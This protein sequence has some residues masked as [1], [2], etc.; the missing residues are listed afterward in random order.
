MVLPDGRPLTVANG[1]LP[2]P[3][4]EGHVILWLPGES[5]G[6][7]QDWERVATVARA[8]VTTAQGVC[9]IAAA[10]VPIRRRLRGSLG[11]LLRAL[12]RPRADRT[13]TLPGGAAAEQCGARRTDLRLAWAEDETAPLDDDRIEALWPRRRESRAIGPNLYLVSGIE[14][15]RPS[16]TT[17]PEPEPEP[18]APPQVS[19]RD[20]AER[21]LA[22]A[23]AAGD[24]RSTI[25]ALADLGLALLL[26]DATGDAATMLEEARVEARRLGDPALEADVLSNLALAAARSGQPE[27]AREFIGPALAYARGVGDR[28]AEKLALD[29]LALA[30]VGLGDHAGALVHLDQAV[31]IAADLGDRRHEADLLWRAAIAHAELGRR[32]RALACAE[33]AVDRLRRLANPTADWYAQHVE[34]YRSGA[35]GAALAGPPALIASPGPVTGPGTLRMA[36]TAAKAMAAFVGSGFRTTSPKSYRARLAV[37]AA[38]EH[39]TGI[40]CRLCGCI[41]AAKARML[42]ERCPAGRWRA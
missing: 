13:W 22:A 6:G 11:D 28:Y 33:A 24:R 12:V 10:S 41:T 39:H 9:S 2:E 38:C 31:A 40:R 32:D 21:A 1:I 16:A 18:K 27:R 8:A 14:S 4:S 5:T 17:R 30:L 25:T 36:L 34:N 26:E 19:P 15:E 35:A 23:R 37:C 42:H 29:R 7:Y 3:S 20:L